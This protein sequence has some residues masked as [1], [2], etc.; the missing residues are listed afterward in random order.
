MNIRETKMAI[1]VNNADIA[2]STNLL[3]TIG[4]SRTVTTTDDGDIAQTTTTQ[5]TRQILETKKDHPSLLYPA[6]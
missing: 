1:T 3:E 4:E 5:D 2:G 6:N